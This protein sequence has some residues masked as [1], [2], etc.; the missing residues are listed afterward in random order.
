MITSSGTN[1]YILDPESSEEMVRLINLDR[2][3][4]TNMGGPFDGIVDA[5]AISTVLDI[6]C[7]PGGWVLDVAYAYPNINVA[8]IDISNT[9]ITYANAR[10]RSQGLANASFGVMDLNQPL[11]FDDESFDLVNARF[12][13]STLKRASW[14]IFIAQCTQLLRPGGILRLTEQTGHITTSP[15]QTRMGNLFAKSLWLNGHGFSSDGTMV[16]VTSVLP[17]LLRKAGY[18]QV[19]HIARALE[20]SID[21]SNWADGY[22]NAEIIGLSFK[23][24]FVRLGLT[25]QEEGDTWYQQMLVELHADDYCA[26]QHYMTVIGTRS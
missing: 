26:M 1:K 21:T 6:G 3:V 17:F 13:F 25:T 9:M 8:G 5:S 19:R 14:P 2:M 18:Q 22:R 20:Y 16:G 7:G 24:L 23:D 12:L 4:T 10:A 11:D 15:A